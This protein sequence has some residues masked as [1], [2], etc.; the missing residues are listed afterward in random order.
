LKINS[1]KIDLFLLL[2][3]EE[4]MDGWINIIDLA[5]I[6]QDTDSLFR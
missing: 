2:K 4:I 1:L 6:D 5:N 3:V